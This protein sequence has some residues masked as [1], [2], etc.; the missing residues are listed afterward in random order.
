MIKKIVMLSLCLLSINTMAQSDTSIVFPKSN[1]KCVEIKTTCSHNSSLTCIKTVCGYN[2]N[3]QILDDF[4]AKNELINK[5]FISFLD[6]Q[7]YFKDNLPKELRNYKL[8]FASETTSKLNIEFTIL[9]TVSNS[10]RIIK[11][12]L[13]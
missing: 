10:N 1:K 9:V 12:E 2:I 5:T 4:V 8:Q 7:N 3:R 13:F 11:V 6:V